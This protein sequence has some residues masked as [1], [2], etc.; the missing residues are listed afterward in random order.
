MTSWTWRRPSTRRWSKS[1]EQ[2]RDVLLFL[3]LAQESHNSGL[4]QSFD[5]ALVLERG[6]R[7]VFSGPLGE[8]S[9]LLI[10]HLQVRDVSK[11]HITRAS[12][13]SAPWE[14]GPACS[15]T[16]SRCGGSRKNLSPDYNYPLRVLRPKRAVQT[17]CDL[18]PGEWYLKAQFHVGVVSCS[19]G[20]AWRCGVQ[21]RRQSRHLGA[22]SRQRRRRAARRQRPR[23]LVQQQPPPRV[24]SSKSEPNLHVSG[25]RVASQCPPK[26]GHRT[27]VG[28]PAR[29][30]GRACV[31]PINCP[32]THVWTKLSK[33]CSTETFPRHSAFVTLHLPRQCRRKEALLAQL[34]RPLVGDTGRPPPGGQPLAFPTRY[35]CGWVRQLRLCLRKNNTICWCALCLRLRPCSELDCCSA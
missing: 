15:R 17:A 5:E 28:C 9:S 27:L 16:T 8:R 19:A 11:H 7:V 10:K 24:R 30:D 6:G 13:S 35:A 26:V 21:G 18:F 14:R 34:G 29:A 4:P 33:H 23:R 2:G 31:C 1:W 3:Y 12:C 20:R 25:P 22:G 32:S